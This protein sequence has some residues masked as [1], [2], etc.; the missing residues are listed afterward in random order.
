MDIKSKNI[1]MLFGIRKYEKVI[2][3]KKKEKKK[4]INSKMHYCVPL[5]FLPNKANGT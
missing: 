1:L 4:Y 5:L 3:K 2:V